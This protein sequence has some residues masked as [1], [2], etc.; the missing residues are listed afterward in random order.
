M[1]DIIHTIK[2]QKAIIHLVFIPIFLGVVVVP[3]AMTSPISVSLD[4]WSYYFIE[5]FQAKGAL[6]GFLSNTKPYSRD[7]MADMIVHILDLAENGE[8]DLSEVEKE[9]LELMK[10]EFATELVERGITGVAEYKHP[11]N[12][13]SG[14]KN[15]VAEIGYTQ[16]GVSKKGTEDYKMYRGTLQVILW[17]N[18]EGGLF[19]YNDSRTSYEHSEEP[20]PLWNPYVDVDRY[21]W[22]AVSDAYLIFR[23]PWADVQVGKDAV[24]WGP[25]YHGVIGLSGV[26]PT[27]DIVKLPIRLWKVKFVSILGFLRDDLIKSSGGDIVRK[28]LFGH[29]VEIRPFTGFCIGWQEVYI[30][31]KLH[32]ELLNP[33]MPYQMAEDYLGQVGNNTMAGDIDVCILPNMRLY[34]SLFLDDLHLDESFFKY[35]P[36]TWAVLGGFLIVDPFG[37]EDSD[38]RAEYARIEPWVY[39]HRGIIQNPPILTSYKHFDTP[40]GH[41][42]GPNAD[43]LFFEIN[44][45][46]SRDLLT[47][48]SY[49]RIRKGEVGGSIYDYFTSMDMEKR[50]L[51]GIVEKKRTISL[52]LE[53]RVFQDSAIEINYSHT[54]VDNKQKEAAKLPGSDSRKQPWEARH[55]WMQNTVQIAITLRY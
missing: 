41:W 37:V 47:T 9:Q 29:R 11:L 54:R 50:F 30:Y 40:L 20:L 15:L 6:R 16:D 3:C 53:Y 23:F 32:L 33:I 12:W 55:N 28:Y 36:N 21:P 14:G 18:L 1:D 48:V 27:F 34:A 51:M 26:E 2:T 19:F 22:N 42:I 31:N 5:R 52:G 43:D 17:G 13:S 24:L 35:T 45:W 39:P 46:F 49:N 8:V 44:H 10:S 25:G 38:F 7:E 4:L